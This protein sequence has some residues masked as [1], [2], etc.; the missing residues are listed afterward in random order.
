MDTPVPKIAKIT[1]LQFMQ[2]VDLLRKYKQEFLDLRPDH[3][4]TAGMLTTRCGFNVSR[5]TAAKVKEA[6]GVMWER[7]GKPR[8]G[9]RFSSFNAVGTLARAV[10][11]LYGNLGEEKPESLVRLI[12][13]YNRTKTENPS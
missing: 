11:Q 7:R 2:A 10:G 9:S 13:H 8:N 12:E 3:S 4:Q 6:S 1:H 5:G